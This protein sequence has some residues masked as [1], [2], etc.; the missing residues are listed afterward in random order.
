MSIKILHTADLHIDSPFAFLPEEKAIF[1]R[2][3]QLGIL[4]EIVTLAE[5]HRV[6][7][8][9]ICGDLFDSPNISFDVTSSVSDILSSTAIPVFIAPGNHDYFHLG[10]PYNLNVWPENV[11]IFKSSAIERIELPQMTLYGA[12][13]TSPNL[14]RSTLSNF[15]LGNNSDTGGFYKPSVIMLHGELNPREPIYHPV[16]T[17][18][19]AA[20][21]ADYLALGH[22]HSRTEP[23]K[24]GNTVFAFSGCPEGRGFDETGSKGMYLV[25]LGRGVN[26]TFLPLSGAKY[27]DLTV[28]LTGNDSPA[29]EIINALP[30]KSQEDLFRIT[31]SG[32]IEPNLI[33]IEEISKSIS[34]LVFYAEIINRTKLPRDI[35]SYCSEDTLRG[36]FLSLLREKMDESASNEDREIIDLAARYGLDALE[37]EE[38]DYLDNF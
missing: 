17:N 27:Y 33:S 3:R 20:C 13:F 30:S 18:D 4:E 12:G 15:S 19:I 2:R 37:G 22:I 23:Q 38:A 11:H 34:P 21:G 5:H 35:W 29:K 1:R 36:T 7:A 24:V 6:D 26:M 25:E 14:F 10:S 16:Y 9:L 8:L 32:E 28:N 31:L